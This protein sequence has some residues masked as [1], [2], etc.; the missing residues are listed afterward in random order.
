MKLIINPF[1]NAYPLYYQYKLPNLKDWIPTKYKN[2]KDW[3]PTKIKRKK[4][5]D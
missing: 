4:A 2:L 5:N 1:R 3:T